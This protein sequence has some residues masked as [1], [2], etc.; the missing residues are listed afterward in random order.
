[1]GFVVSLRHFAVGVS[2]P[3]TLQFPTSGWST[4]SNPNQSK[5]SAKEAFTA[6][7]K[8]RSPYPLVATSGVDWTFQPHSRLYQTIAPNV[9]QHYNNYKANKIDK[10]YVP[11]YFYLGGTGT[12]KSRHASEFASSVLKAATRHTNDVQ[13]V[14]RLKRSF[15]FHISFEGGTPLAFDELNDPWNAIGV[16]M[17][18]QLLDEPIA[19]IRN[20]YAADPSTVLEL[21]AEAEHVDFYEEFTGILVVDGIHK[22]LSLYGGK[23]QDI[24]H[25][26]LGLIH[27]LS[28]M[29]RHPS[30][31]MNGAS[32]AA[33]FI[34]TCITAT[35]FGSIQGFLADS[36]RKRVQ[37]P[38]NRLDAPIWNYNNASV[39]SRDSLTR[40]LADDVGGHARAL[41]LIA[42]ELDR[43]D[44]SE[45]GAAL[46]SGLKD[47]YREA[48][49]I[50]RRHAF[51]ITQYAF[52][53]RPVRLWEM[54]PGS[55]TRWEDAVTA[56]LIWFESTEGDGDY[57]APGYLVVPYIWFWLLARLP[58][59]QESERL[60]QFLKS[61]QFNDYMELLHLA[62]GHLANH[63]RYNFGAFCSSFRIFRSL[64]F[65]DSK[66]VPLRLLH[67]G[68]KLRDDRGTIVVNRQLR[69]LP[70][71]SSTTAQTANI[72]ARQGDH[73][74]SAILNNASFSFDMEMAGRRDHVR[75]IGQCKLAKALN[76]A[77]YDLE[78]IKSAGSD[79]IFMLYTHAETSND[80]SLPD[81]SGLVDGACWDSYFG[82]FS[83]RAYMAW[84][85]RDY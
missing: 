26:L 44:I 72:Y 59:S 23:N 62:S 61:W 68:C 51:A 14:N 76:Q 52:T 85:N 21:V 32:R 4:P 17:L 1:M 42:D 41:E 74:L 25:G 31:T 55:T 45:L 83:G 33:P 57:D 3:V 37:L 49:F 63:P 5:L 48:I 64:V 54:I 50:M 11:I 38:L 7:I 2:A 35:C 34:I 82:P 24:F 77:T 73:K 6:G 40:L 13:L 8:Y 65:E 80:W 43:A 28:L 18:H 58:D 81:R 56:G 67:S 66:E 78:R 16:R 53:R 9:L 36:H 12:G 70:Y 10:T 27:G 60:S 30:Q 79:D 15:V 46:F 75:E 39:F 29:S 22:A 20:R 19:D 47:R 84:V 71:K 69:N